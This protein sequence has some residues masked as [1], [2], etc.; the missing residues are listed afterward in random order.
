MHRFIPFYA[1]QLGFKV[2]ETPVHHRPRIAGEAKYG[3]LNRAI[4]GLRDLIAMRWMRRRLRS[5]DFRVIEAKG[6]DE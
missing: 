1:R 4:P 5:T 6:L 3:I 2:I